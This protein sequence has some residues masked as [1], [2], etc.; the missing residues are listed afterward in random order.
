MQEKRRPLRQRIQV[1]VLLISMLAVVVV[2]AIAVASMENIKN[3][4]E[5]SLLEQMTLNM[6]NIVT[7]KVKIADLELEKFREYIKRDSRFLELVYN[8]PEDFAARNILPPDLSAEDRYTMQRY[9]ATSDVDKAAVREEMSMLGNIESIWTPMM[10]RDGEVICTVYIGTETGFMLS[11]DKNANLAELESDGESY[12]NYFDSY[13]YTKAKE[14]KSVVFTDLTQDAY[15]RGLTL[16]CAAPF[17]NDKVFAGVIA[18]DILVT[19]LQKSIINIDLG[20]GAFAFLVN[21]NGEIVASPFVDLK[22][23]EFENIKDENNEYYDIH[24]KILSGNTGI[25]KTSKNVYCAYSPITV[26][27]W[28]LCVHVPETLI[29]E[30]SRQIEDSIRDVIALFVLSFVAICLVVLVVVRKFS[31]TITD[32]ILA[33]KKDVEVMSNGDLDKQAAIHGNDEISDLAMAF[34]KMTESL[35]KY[36]SDLTSVTAEKERIGAELNVATQIQ[37]SMLPSTFPAFP[38]DKRF[39]IYASMTPAKEVGGDFYDFF[40]IDDKHLAIV[41]ADVSGKGVPA[42]LFMVIGKTLI[43]DHSTLGKGLGEVFQEVNNLLCEANSEGLFITAFEAV[44]NL[45]TG[46][47]TYVNAGHEMPYIYRKGKE[48]NAFEM[49]A[50][51][52]LAGME[53][54]KYKAGTFNIEPGD[55]IFQYTDGVTEATDAHNELYGMD[56]LKKA[57]DENSAKRPNELLP[58]VK[59]DIDKFVGDAPQFDDITMLGFEYISKEK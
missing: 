40:K 53:N 23:T 3:K 51:F 14:A 48:F 57:L 35:K 44:I 32:P 34:N 26:A 19:D 8:H 7:D 18:M 45:E 10:E 2:G 38:D 13:W 9:Y 17:Y 31:E 5:Q 12:Y 16:T 21:R 56:R 42:A 50:A 41:V 46:E 43:K 20:A 11:Y 22:Q 6:Q 55:K 25:D 58:A 47:V 37:S 29:L 27:D 4:S 28:I 1:I 54:M 49:K 52:V 24:D 36:I 33:L 39:D 30:P 15:G 59:A